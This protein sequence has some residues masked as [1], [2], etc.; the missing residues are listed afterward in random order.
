MLAAAGIAWAEPP[1]PVKVKDRHT[2]GVFYGFSFVTDMRGKARKGVWTLRSDGLLKWGTPD[3]P[4]EELEGRGLTANEKDGTTLRA[5]PIY[6]MKSG[7]ALFLVAVG[8]TDGAATRAPLPSSTSTAVIHR[9]RVAMLF[10]GGHQD[11]VTGH[12]GPA[13]RAFESLHMNR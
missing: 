2:L 6:A 7:R 1:A 8:T 12:S 4:L 5:D 3:G 13:R 11:A 9:G 10:M